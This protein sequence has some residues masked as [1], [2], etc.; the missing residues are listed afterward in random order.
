MYLKIDSI[1]QVN[2][3]SIDASQPADPPSAA[4]TSLRYHAVQ[5]W[6]DNQSG[7][8]DIIVVV[9]AKYNEIAFE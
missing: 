9:A 1:A 7:E 4:S 8:K 3:E 2:G 5:T 6:E